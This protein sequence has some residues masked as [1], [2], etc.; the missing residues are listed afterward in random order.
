MPGIFG[1]Y[2]NMDDDLADEMSSL[3]T[4]DDDWFEGKCFCYH[5]HGVHG[6]HGVV[7]FKSQV[8]SNYA[9][10][11]NMSIVTYGDIYLSE[12]KIRHCSVI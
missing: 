1:C 6:F 2:G 3:L 11:N 7:D 4:H 8:E 10:L 9:S 5:F 12:G